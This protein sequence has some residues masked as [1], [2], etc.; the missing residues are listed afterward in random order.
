MFAGSIYFL[1]QAGVSARWRG[2]HDASSAASSAL[3]CAKG[4]S[5]KSAHTRTSASTTR[6]LTAGMPE[7]SSED[8]HSSPTAQAAAAHS[9]RLCS[10]MVA[11]RAHARLALQETA[12]VKSAYSER[13]HTFLCIMEDCNKIQ[14][15]MQAVSWWLGSSQ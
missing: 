8:E 5:A 3:A 11:L 2:S 6:R 4:C 10:S 9:T 15:L 12:D 13:L 7:M 14:G 1:H